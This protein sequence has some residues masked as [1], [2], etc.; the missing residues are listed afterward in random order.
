M[1]NEFSDFNKIKN[2]KDIYLKIMKRFCERN[3]EWKTQN[4]G[5]YDVTGLVE[6]YCK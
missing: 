4:T 5:V 3:K 2:K 1:G 6:K